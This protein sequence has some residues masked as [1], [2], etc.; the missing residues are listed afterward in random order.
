M[1]TKKRPTNAV[2]DKKTNVHKVRASIEVPEL[3]NAGSSLRLDVFN[4]EGK[5]GKLVIGRGSLTWFA[6]NQKRGKR[7]T[8]TDFAEWIG[9]K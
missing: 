7:R 9:A 4:A 5:L 6:R 1:A 3:S 8:W 2:I